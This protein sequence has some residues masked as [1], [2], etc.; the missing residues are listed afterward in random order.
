MP[1][2]GGPCTWSPTVYSPKSY[3]G[4]QTLLTHM[5]HS[6]RLHGLPQWA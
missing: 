5:Q 1:S 6:A 3:L 2:V 4:L